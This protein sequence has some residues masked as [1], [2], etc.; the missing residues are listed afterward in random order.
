MSDSENQ[1]LGICDF[2]LSEGFMA[3]ALEL[4]CA[5]CTELEVMFLAQEINLFLYQTCI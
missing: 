3:S 2:S 1:V 4:A 5:V